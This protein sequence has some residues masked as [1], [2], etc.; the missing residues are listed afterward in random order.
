MNLNPNPNLHPDSD[1]SRFRKPPKKTNPA[2]AGFV[3]HHRYRPTFH[4]YCNSTRYKIR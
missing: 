3:S 1:D 2:K 4:E